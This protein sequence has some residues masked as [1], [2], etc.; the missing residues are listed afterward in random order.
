[1]D[2]SKGA[3]ASRHRW[4]GYLSVVAVLALIASGFAVANSASAAPSPGPSPTAGPR[5]DLF[6]GTVALTIQTTNPLQYTLVDE[7]YIVGGVYSFLM[8]RGPD[9]ELEPDIAVQ[10]AQTSTSPSTWQF[11]LTK[12]AYFVDPRGCTSVGGHITNCPT[13]TLVTADDV[14][15]TF[16]YVKSYA[17]Q[18]SYYQPCVEHIASVS[19][20][21]PGGP[22]DLTITFDGPYAAAIAA[23][24]CV[25]IL[26]RYIW[27]TQAVDWQNALPIGSGPYMVRPVGTTFQMV[28]PPPLFLDRNPHWHGTEVQGRQVF[29]DT[30]QFTSYTTSGAL[31][32][33]LTLGKIDLALSPN[34][35]DYSVFLSGKPGIIRQS[36]PDGFEAE[37]AV[38]VLTDEL[39]A[40]FASISTRPLERGSA[41]P[42]LQEQVVRTAI[43]M[44]TN[45]A[46]MIANAQNGLA[47]PGDTL[48]PLFHPDHL[49]IPPYSSDDK[50]SDGSPYDFPPFTVSAL[51][52]FPDDASAPAAARTMLNQA[53]WAYLCSTNTLDTG[54]G[55]PLCRR[56]GAGRAVEPLTFRFSTFNTEP[57]WETAARGVIEDAAKSGI[58]FNLEL[59]NPSQM[60]N[61]WYRLDYEVWLWDWVW[62]PVTDPSL[63]LVVQTCHGIETLDNDN[64][65]CAIDPVTGRWTF[66]DIYN[67]TLTETDPVARS[68]LVAQ[69]Q[70]MIY[71]YGSYNLPFYLDQLYA[72]NEVRWTNWGD[73]RLQRAV[74]P[75]IGNSP[76][77]GQVV[78]P[79]DQKPPQFSLAT[80]EGV[81]GQ[82][83][84][85]SVA[86]VD[87]EGA[88]VTYRWDFDTSAD[89]GTDGIPW[90]DNQAST[91]T[92]TFTYGAAGTYT[93]AL[94]VSDGEFFTEKRTTVSIHAPGTG[95]PTVRA[96][97]FSPS[98]PTTFSGDLAVLA[99]SATDPA[100]LA[101]TQ[102]TWNWGDGTAATTT[103]IPTASHQYTSAGTFTAQVTVRNSNGVTSPT[104]STLVPVVVNSAPVLSPL[105]DQSVLVSTENSYVAFA[106]EPNKRDV[107][108]YSWTFG[109]TDC[110]PQP[111]CNTATGNPVAHIYPTTGTKTLTVAVSDAHGHS[112]SSSATVSVVPTRNTAPNI[113]SLTSFPT[114][115]WT[116]KPVLI[117]AS[118]SDAE[119]NPLLWQWDF[120]NDGTIDKSYT[121][122][123]T[124]P[125][126]TTVRQETYQY[127]ATGNQRTKLTVIDQ[128]PAPEPSKSTFQ[129]VTTTVSANTVPTLTDITS[130]PSTGIAGETF[131]FSST[132][133]DVNGD[134]LS[135]TWEFGDGTSASGQT[136]FFGGA[137]SA[138]HAYMADGEY[139]AVLIVNDGKGG[140]ARKSTL[141]NVAS[142]G[143]LRV[144]TNPAVS[145]KILVDGV[146]RDEWGL[147]W[148]KI[149]PGPHTVSFG[150]VPGFATPVDQAVTV[151]AG[152]TTTAV[153]N[154]ASLGFLRVMTSPALASTISVNGVPRNDWGMWTAL[155]PGTYTV[156]YGAVQGYNPPADQSATVTVGATTTITGTFSPNPSAPGPDPATFGLL[157]VTT[158]PAVPSQ[159]LVNNVPRD[160]Y[161]LAWV[162]LPPGTYT[163]SF[164][165]VYGFTS[166]APIQVTVSAG[167]TTVYDAPF[168]AHGS[169][170]V[171]TS[172]AVAGTIFVDG[173][174]RDD[175]GMWQSMP[176]GTYKVSF[177]PVAGYITPASQTAIVTA[178]APPTTITGVYTT[179]AA[180]SPAVTTITSSELSSSGPSAS[181]PSQDASSLLIVADGSEVPTAVG[182]PF[183]SDGVAALTRVEEA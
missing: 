61:L 86:A 144:T 80:F 6:I 96:V 87:P 180:A 122:P 8:N 149:A 130:S 153:G 67:Q 18:T 124:A 140:E 163:V 17:A 171:M 175:W 170:R 100:G 106:S 20:N 113:L 158:N 54:V 58:Q 151:T 129:T 43:H 134:R 102:Y 104:S 107:L 63:A 126:G 101:L 35:Q 31:A 36:V 132:S 46:K 121:T 143:L 142:P 5:H 15:F 59:V 88:P 111:G 55:A 40:H 90:N 139:V 99:A 110:T 78:H 89:V 29:P 182:E 83:V 148:M 179:A 53:G 115:S 34:A 157:R 33:D 173:V 159:I 150:G 155:A 161:G 183:A 71:S 56:D 165:Q 12:N 27:A 85:F 48:L 4:A 25:P 66:D 3:V 70:N 19:I 75:D 119:G 97:S 131:S 49:V 147:A 162:K 94:R 166:P 118:I 68:A 109:D 98:D 168:A 52:Q 65:Y 141:V 84:P 146:P 45:R 112:V 177:G 77:I 117:N 95:S 137:I 39:R 79:L 93:V 50:N 23:V 32:V 1:M 64:G 176:P 181:V 160:D 82:P 51:E 133:N 60:F 28:T 74:P 128:P 136:G 145:G 41:N 108:S 91:A 156:H 105:S 37:Q 69:A 14:K 38:N 7:Y 30:M 72:L 127:P 81:T 169:L 73:F 47:T 76:L 11:K 42:I 57:W 164:S 21:S 125:G 44:A 152:A 103:A 120:G 116:T 172:P 10:W 154:Y 9:W 2:D 16:D 26:P 178:G 123:A 167:A 92:P 135:F 13:K 24:T 174:P 62:S 138:N 22:Y 114:A